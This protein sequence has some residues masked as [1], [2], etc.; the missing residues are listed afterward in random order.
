MKVQVRRGVFETNSSNTHSLT[1][2]TQKEYDEW[3][4]GALWLKVWDEELVSLDDI[5]RDF[6][7]YKLRDYYDGETFEEWFE[8]EQ[9]DH[10]YQSYDNWGDDYLEGYSHNFTTP[11]GDEMVVFGEFGRDG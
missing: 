6:E 1:V 2:C 10:E 3:V 4:H 7:N 9:K 5:K 11:S 8:A